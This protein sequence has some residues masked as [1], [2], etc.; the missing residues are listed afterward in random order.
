MT[1]SRMN[2]TSY[3]YQKTGLPEVSRDFRQLLQASH[4]LHICYR[5][6]IKC[7][8]GGQYYAPATLLPEKALSLSYPCRKLVYPRSRYKQSGG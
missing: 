8:I 7:Y 5:S 3:L 6:V 4:R 1:C 2:F